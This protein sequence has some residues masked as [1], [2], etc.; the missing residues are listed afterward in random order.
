[1][2]E[3]LATHPAIYC[4]KGTLL[5]LINKDKL[6]SFNFENPAFSAIAAVWETTFAC[7]RHQFLSK[8][9][10]YTADYLRQIS[11]L[12]Q[13]R[14]LIDISSHHITAIDLYLNF[15]LSTGLQISAGDLLLCTADYSSW[16]LLCSKV[17]SMV[18]IPVIFYCDFES[19]NDLFLISLLSRNHFW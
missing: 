1:M 16:G 15:L 5:S 19:I 6:Q 3:D 12:W 7:V 2:A 10:H 4:S 14:N 9:S 13:E 17:S 18:L 11:Y 8:S